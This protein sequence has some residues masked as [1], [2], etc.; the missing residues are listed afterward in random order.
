MRCNPD[1]SDFEVFAHGLRNV[2]ELAFDEFGNLFGVDNDADRPGEKE[3]FVYIVKGMDAGWRCNYQYRGNDF[4][5]WTDEKLWQPQHEG[6]PAYIVP[7]ISSYENGPCGFVYNP[8]TALSPEWARTFF[9]TEAPNG[10]QWAFQVEPDGPS[11]KMVNSRQIGAGVRLIGLNFGP[12]GALYGVDWANGYPLNQTGAVWKIDVP[13]V[14]NSAARVETQQLLASD[15]G[16]T[17]SARLSTLLGHADQRVRLKAQF[18]L[19]NRKDLAVFESGLAS[20]NQLA[21]IHSVWGLGQLNAVDVL[22]TNAKHAD[23]EIQAQIARTASDLEAFDED[24]I[25]DWIA[26]EHPRVRYFGLQAFAAHGTPDNYPPVYKAVEESGADPYFRHAGAQAMT[27]LESKELSA[28]VGNGYENLEL[29]AIVAL[30]EMGSL[31]V[32]E[33][34]YEN[35]RSAEEAA[36]AIHDD[37][38][39][40]SAFWRLAMAL[41]GDKI[42]TSEPYLRRV[43]N[44]NFRLGEPEN[45]ERVVAFAAQTDQPIEMRLDAIDALENWLNP[46]LLDRVDGRRRD[47][48]PRQKSEIGPALANH[49]PLLLG[50]ADPKIRERA[51]AL[52]RQFDIKSD[53]SRL[54]K[55]IADENSAASL[56]VQALESLKTAVAIDAAL[57]SDA[58]ALRIRARQLLAESDPDR[59]V[60]LLSAMLEKAAPIEEEQA[61][62]A[63]LTKLESPGAD[64]ALSKWL[65]KLEVGNVR[66]GIQLDLLEAAETRGLDAKLTRKDKDPLADWIECLEGGDAIQGA[67]VFTAHIAAQCV[68]CHKVADGEGSI[69]GPNLKSAGL[70]SRRDLLE[71]LVNPT[72][73]ITEG[74]GT[75][76]LL[77]KDGSAVAGQF[78]SETEEHIELRDLEGKTLKVSKAKVKERSPAISMMPPMTAILTKREIRDVVAYLKTLNAAP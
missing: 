42:I 16:E 11:F 35:P 2:Q 34:L 68:R 12:D 57:N 50:D 6:Q 32:G 66:A 69:I 56:R 58:F 64:Q 14:A 29:A 71:S 15:F 45:A 28:I 70:Q 43:I 62:I 49:L 72:A 63:T 36:R 3:R 67:N 19:A 8:G 30:R 37:F 77:M 31:H 40:P 59:V 39:I 1:G 9:M 41:R 27:R 55:M 75:I 13:G 60:K 47:L 44:A 61:A 25:L 53:P 4:N 74:F 73:K 7:P 21:A 48:E 17:E 5:P 20:Q 65:S 23:P 10:K 22:Q 52:A 18:E 54:L 26:S 76:T 24:S 33:F 46:P 51:L 78:I 38:S